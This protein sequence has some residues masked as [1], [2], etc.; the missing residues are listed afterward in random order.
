MV[1]G[2]PKGFIV[3]GACLLHTGTLERIDPDAVAKAIHSTDRTTWVHLR[4]EDVD[5]GREF[6]QHELKLDPLTVEDALSDTE[7][8]ALKE[9]PNYIFLSA[10]SVED[11]GTG[12]EFIDVAFFV[13]EHSLV[14]VVKK[15][16][17]SFEEWFDRWC[18]RAPN[19]GNHP[20]YLLHAMLDAIVDNYFPVMDKLE[21]Q[22]ESLADMV[23]TGRGM[24]LQEAM[25]MKRRLLEARRKI[26]PIRDVINGLLRRDVSFVPADVKPYLQDVYDHT[27]RIA[28]IVDV[29]R[30]TLATLLDAHLAV[31][32]NNL[33]VV[34]R[35]MT[36]YATILMTMSLVAGVYGM[37]FHYMPEL[38]W[39]LGYPFAIGLMVVLGAIEFWLFK[40][41]D[42]L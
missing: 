5:K 29:N 38:Q 39:R 40:R 35:K 33:N 21:D 41:K 26:A 18:E 10:A 9:T 36:V 42:W 16:A 34:M 13:F 3:Q 6:L 23:F 20:A 8:P 32:S 15:P 28:D 1:E 14:T 7:R 25:V 12:E 17:P 30:D 4:I 24:H 19:F 31:V 27:L 22:V 11:A 37:N 2:D